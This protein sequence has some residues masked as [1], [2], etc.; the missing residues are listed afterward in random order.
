[1]VARLAAHLTSVRAASKYAVGAPSLPGVQAGFAAA[2]Q[3]MRMR[4][5][6]L[7]PAVSHCARK[8][9]HTRP[10]A[11]RQISMTTSL[12]D[13]FIFLQP[14]TEYASAMHHPKQTIAPEA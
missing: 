2:T 5:V 9:R 1:M 7:L 6:D 8:R 11:A 12:Y 4:P 3:V 13:R 14:V 10:T